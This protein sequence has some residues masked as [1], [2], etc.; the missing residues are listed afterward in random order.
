MVRYTTGHAHLRRHNK[1]AGT[2]EPM[3]LTRPEPLYKLSDPDDKN[4]PDDET[5]RCRLC[6]IPGKEETPMHIFQD[7]LAT[8]AKR[9]NI[10]GEY[11]FEEEHTVFWEP[12]DIVGF[13]E[14]FDLENRQN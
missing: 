14:H 13:F 4:I 10:F 5:I 7:C 12:A 2:S 3:A 9:R 1:I 6:K 8:W 11:I